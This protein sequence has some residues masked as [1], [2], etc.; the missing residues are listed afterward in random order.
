MASKKLI[1]EILTM[2]DNIYRKDRE[3]LVDDE[4]TVN[5]YVKAFKYAKNNDLKKAAYEALDNCE[6][7][8]RPA[9]IHKYFP[10][11]ESKKTI[12][13]D[14][15]LRDRFTCMKCGKRVTALMGTGDRG[16]CLLCSGFGGA[17]LGKEHQIKLKE[18]GTD[19]FIIE[20]NLRCNGCGKVGECIKEPPDAEHWLC[21]DCYGGTTKEGRVLRFKGVVNLTKINVYRSKRDR[22]LFEVKN[23]KHLEW[24]G[25]LDDQQLKEVKRRKEA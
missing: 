21:R 18:P 12:Q 7:Y 16:V 5:T 6:Y 1:I 22:K 10:R 4:L 19:L 3:P 17:Q 8:P 15:Y 23:V 14:Q 13:N 25:G 11:Q 9:E 20:G 2:F 24:L